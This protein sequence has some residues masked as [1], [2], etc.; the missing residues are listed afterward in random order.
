MQLNSILNETS[1]DYLKSKFEANGGSQ[2]GTV[3]QQE[4]SIEDIEWRM[5]NQGDMNYDLLAKDK[6]SQPNIIRDSYNRNFWRKE[7]EKKYYGDVREEAE[8]KQEITQRQNKTERER[9]NM[10]VSHEVQN[11]I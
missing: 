4:E 1:P 11:T 6:T 2:R 5:R 7:D 10:R 3:K 8:K 9:E